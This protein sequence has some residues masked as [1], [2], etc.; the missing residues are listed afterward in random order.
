MRNQDLSGGYQ[1]NNIE[2]WMTDG[3]LKWLY[4]TALEC[5]R[6]AE[7]GC[8]MGRSTHALLSGCKG[9]VYAID[10]FNG[11][12]SEIDTLH[13]RARTEDIQQIFLSNVGRFPNLITLKMDSLVAST[14]FSDKWFDMVFLDGEH[15]FEAVRADIEAWLPKCKRI[16]CGHDI[17]MGGVEPAL[18]DAGLKFEI[19]EASIWVVR[20]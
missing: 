9:R 14:M 4:K 1:G 10:H 5:D 3:E 15:T 11:S 19:E 13:S 17:Q 20:L 8:W 2:G 18:K 7:I 16:F 12:P 6:I